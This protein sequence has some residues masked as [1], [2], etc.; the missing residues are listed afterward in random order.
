M[1]LHKKVL[2]VVGLGLLLSG[3][4]LVAAEKSA[5][6]IVSNSYTY[7]SSMDKYA[8]SA[9]VSVTDGETAKAYKQNISAKVSRPD[10]L[11]VDTNGDIKNRSSYLN[12]G[13]YTMMDHAAGFYGQIKTPKSIDGALD[14]IFTEF[15]I[16][17]PMSTLFYSDMPKRMKIKNGKYFGTVNVAGV[18]CDYVAF[19]NNTK[20]IHAWIAT[21]DKPLVKT[22]SVID[23]DNF[24]MNTSLTWTANANISDSNFVFKA[25]KNASKITVNSAK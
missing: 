24:R 8:F 17:S 5:S 21:G 16:K 15:G 7:L 12:N 13:I 6:D 2:S 1:K 9:V 3:T 19:R 14:F 10:M 11:R 23:Q 18:E 20:E 25:P 22:Y 4:N